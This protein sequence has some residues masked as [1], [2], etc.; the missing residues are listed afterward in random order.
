MCFF[1]H[2][3]RGPFRLRMLPLTKKVFIPEVRKD[4]EGMNLVCKLPKVEEIWFD[5]VDS[6]S[7][8]PWFDFLEKNM[9][10]ETGIDLVKYYDE[11][12]FYEL[13]F[14]GGEVRDRNVNYN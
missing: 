1:Y 14:Y 13:Y 2:N 10:K 6:K 4:V 8:D 11:M 7:L 5:D 12:D 9:D 3:E